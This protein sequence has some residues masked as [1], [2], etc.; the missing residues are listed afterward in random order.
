MIKKTLYS[1]K[2]FIYAILVLI[3]F[4]GIIITS[5]GLLLYLM[6]GFK[7]NILIGT[8]GWFLITLFPMYFI[9]KYR[10][11]WDE[12]YEKRQVEPPEL[13][14]KGGDVIRS[15]ISVIIF[16]MLYNYLGGF[17]GPFPEHISKDITIEILKII[18]QINGVLIGLL[19]IALSQLY[20]NNLFKFNPRTITITFISFIIS[21][22]YSITNL[23]KLEKEIY[24]K[25]IIVPPLS[26]LI[27]GICLF[28]LFILNAFYRTQVIPLN[29]NVMSTN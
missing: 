14:I 11:V 16:A 9:K 18:T 8:L 22:F 15:I 6:T 1:S 27:F 24:A 3:S 10:D 2:I 4:F 5:F 13:P 25:E 20:K 28:I 7:F 21:I 26:F 29:N 17:L 12:Y 19:G 23:T